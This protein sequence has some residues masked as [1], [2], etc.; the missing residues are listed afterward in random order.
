[1]IRSIHIS[2][3]ALIDDVN[4]ELSNSLNIITGETGAGKSIMLGALSL[5]LGARADVKVVTDKEKKSIIEAELDVSDN[6]EIKNFFV[7]NSLD[8][9]ADATA[10]LRREI[11]PTGRSRAFINDT[12]VNLST[13]EDLSKRLIDIHSQHQSLLLANDEFQLRIIDT[14]ARDCD[15]LEKYKSQYLDYK[16]TLRAYSKA[17]KECETI[18]NKYDDLASQLEALDELKLAS[19]EQEELEKENELLENFQ[20]VKESVSF[21]LAQ[22]SDNDESVS[23]ALRKCVAESED[24]RSLVPDG[25]SLSE[26]LNSLLIELNDIAASYERIDSDLSDDPE[27]LEWIQ[28]RLDAIYRLEK[29]YNVDDVDQLIAIRDSIDEKLQSIDNSEFMLEKLQKDAKT[30]KALVLATAKQLSNV[31]KAE[32]ERFMAELKVKALPLGMRNIEMEAEFTYTNELTSTGID[33]VE[34]KFAFNKNQEK[35]ALSKTASGG[36]ISRLMLCVK[37]ILAKRMQFPT[38]IFDEIDTGVSGEIADKMGDMMLDISKEVQVIA[39][40][41][42]PQV[43]AKGVTHFKVYKEDDEQRTNTRLALLVG[44]SRIN[45]I[46]VMLSGS[47]VEEAAVANAKSLL[48]MKK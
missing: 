9:N 11:S 17:K 7:D 32:A 38:I 2:N 5:L 42:L 14:L 13:L 31:R 18:K 6:E 23:D 20:F 29:K 16:N 24:I 35:L 48:N 1:M 36:E 47:K 21:I 12:P 25:D 30:K 8:W 46:A 37:S 43:A 22:L 10:I 44:E 33:H 45:E 19:G 27:R 3:Y 39:I 28:N 34:F 40:T 4:I 15:L 26:R 41:H